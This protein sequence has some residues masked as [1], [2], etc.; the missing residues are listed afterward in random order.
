MTSTSENVY[1]EKSDNIVKLHMM[2]YQ[3]A[4]K[5]KPIAIYWLW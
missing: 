1:I 5:M 2:K 3:S 4:I